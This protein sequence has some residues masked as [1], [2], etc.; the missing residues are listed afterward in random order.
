MIYLNSGSHS[1]TPPRILDAVQR[2]QREYE[3][4]PT[5]GLFQ[6]WGRLWKVQQ[7][8]ARFFGADPRDI[9]FRSNV[10]EVLNEFILG[11]PLESVN[12]Q[13]PDIAITDLEYGAIA[14]LVRFRCRRD[15]L[16]EHT[17][18]LPGT[19]AEIQKLT[20]ESVVERIVSQLTPRTRMLVCSDVVT[21]N[22]L[23]LP[24]EA[25]AQETRRRG[26]FLV[27]DGAHGPGSQD[28]DFRRYSNVDFYGGNL[29]KWM[30]G[31]K[32]TSFGW[33]NPLH[34]EKLQN[35]QAGWTTFETSPV[36]D[37]F[38]GGSRFA[39]RMLMVGCQD[40]APFFALE[41]LIDYWE[42]SGPAKIRS[43]I[44]ELQ[45]DLERKLQ[46]LDLAP[47]SPPRG[48]L[49][50][51]LLSFELPERA[52]AK[53]LDLFFELAQKHGL[54]VIFPLMH[55]QAVLRVSPHIYNTPEEHTDAV[56]IL[57]R[58]LVSV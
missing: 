28:I 34:Q 24:I 52:R 36:F 29:H 17:I 41:D 55:G 10:T 11:M 18:K 47:L 48:P 16:G 25:L 27:V 33:V 4:N 35:I 50:G 8:V 14:N 31:P 30:M 6:T 39:S 13:A 58:V 15:G 51:P 7:R 12:G 20:P 53:S 26:I 42:E 44:Y 19:S 56:E 43:R 57:R 38:G 46:K 2:Y 54:Q 49:R 9:F 22:G 32:G 3:C 45:A 21:F 23:V 40:F 5:L 37:S 1:I